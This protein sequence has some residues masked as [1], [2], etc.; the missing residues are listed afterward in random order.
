MVATSRHLFVPL[1]ADEPLSVLDAATGE[2]LR[3]FDGTPPPQQVLLTGS[4]LLIGSGQ[5]IAAVAPETG[6][7]KWQ[8]PG[9][10]LA[11]AGDRGHVLRAGGDKLACLSLQDGQTLW[12]TAY[13][14]AAQTLG[15]KKPAAGKAGFAGSLQVGTGVVLAPYRAGLKNSETMVLDAATGRPLWVLAYHDRPFG[16]GGGP[17]I[18]ED[19]LVVFDSV[20]GEVRTLDTR[21]GQP[22]NTLAAPAIRYAG[23]HPRCYESRLTPRFII[24]K[25]RGADFV[26]LASGKVTWCNWLRGSCHRGAI[27]ANGLLYA[28]QHSCRCYTEAALR[29]LNALAPRSGEAAAAPRPDAPVRLE[30][31]P[32]FETLSSTESP[33]SSHD[34]WPTYRHDA[35]RS[36]ASPCALGDKLAPAWTAALS[37][38]LTAPVV[39]DGRLAV[40]ATDQHAVHAFDASTG[41]PLW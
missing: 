31:G 12:E 10:S 5:H 6:L 9:K 16:D 3:T 14:Q 24:G 41:K 2:V 32:V 18:T 21:T 39:G 35:A 37:G 38:R 19:G 33:A 17:F 27:P 40:A 26:D 15:V 30:R 1:A 7:T 11:A 34:D 13:A 28:G 36:G 29:G 23:H 22:K 20:S 4:L 8:A 25:Q